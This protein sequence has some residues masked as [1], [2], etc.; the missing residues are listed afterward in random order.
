MYR[1]Y[2]DG[3]TNPTD[4]SHKKCLAYEKCC[5]ALQCAYP[6]LTFDSEIVYG[7]LGIR[8]HMVRYELD[9]PLMVELRAFARD[10]LAGQS[11]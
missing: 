1:I 2:I 7:V 10:F 8:V 11:F 5:V 4:C 9:S 6:T 3:G